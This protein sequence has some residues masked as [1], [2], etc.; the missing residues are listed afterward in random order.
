[1]PVK[2]SVKQLTCSY[3]VWKCI[4]CIKPLHKL[5]YHTK[6]VSKVFQFIFF[7]LFILEIL[8]HHQFYPIEFHSCISNSTYFK[9]IVYTQPSNLQVP[10]C[11]HMDI[12]KADFF[13]T[14]S[15]C[16]TV[17]VLQIVQE[18]FKHG[19]HVSMYQFDQNPILFVSTEIRFLKQSFI[20]SFCKK[21]F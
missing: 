5:F 4:S 20:E 12:I 6:H 21:C 3:I 8:I 14:H 18:I 1:M 10:K 19:C 16:I 9:D 13:A 7:S 2:F 15:S 17:H 11:L